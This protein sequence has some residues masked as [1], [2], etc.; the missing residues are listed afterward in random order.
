M[1]ET[2]EERLRQFLEEHTTPVLGL[3]EGCML[4]VEGR[5]LELRGTTNARLFRRDQ[6]AAEFVPPHDLSFLL[7]A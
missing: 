2:R 5:R 6:A 4:R 7:D 1:S 3:R